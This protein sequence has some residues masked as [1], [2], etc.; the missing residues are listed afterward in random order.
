MAPTVDH[1]ADSDSLLAMRDPER[2]ARFIND[3]LP[4]LSQLSDRARR[5]TCNG[6][7]A[8]DLVQ[9]TM[10]KAYAGFNTFSEGTNLRAWLFR[11]MTNTYINYLLR[12][13]HRPSEYLI[14]HIIDRQLV[15]PRWTIPGLGHERSNSMHWTRCPT[16][17]S[18]TRWRHCQCGSGSLFTIAISQNCGAE[19][20]PIAWSAARAP[21]CHVCTAGAKDY[22][23]CCSP[24]TNE[25]QY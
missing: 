18:P 23:S 12:A 19:R 25:R 8:E 17:N 3:A 24:H 21:S 2:T 15:R 7:D 13:H 22:E 16:S 9:E 10:L 5:L 4:H 6:V 20:A 14:D 11:I 1:L